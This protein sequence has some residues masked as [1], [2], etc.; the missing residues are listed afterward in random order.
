MKVNLLL[1]NKKSILSGYNN[2]DIFAPGNDERIKCDVTKLDNIS[3]GEL[4]SLIARN[5]LTYFGQKT[6]GQIL[7]GWL[8]KIQ[9]NGTIVIQDIDYEMVSFNV[10]YGKLSLNEASKLL[11]GNQDHNWDSR[12]SG[13]TMSMIVE[14]LELS[15]F[16]ILKKRYTDNQ[17]FVV[18]AQ[19]IV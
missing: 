10:A 19:R 2:Y 1:N 16:K 7:I 6:I 8:K 5:I 4:E 9:L 17:E 11:W 13:L 3:D 14:L 18:E 12:K 15:N